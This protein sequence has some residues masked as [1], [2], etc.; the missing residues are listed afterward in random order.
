MTKRTGMPDMEVLIYE[1]NLVRV[2][3]SCNNVFVKLIGEERQKKHLVVTALLSRRISHI[4]LRKLV[5]ENSQP[6]YGLFVFRDY[7]DERFALVDSWA[8][9]VVIWDSREGKDEA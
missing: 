7:L 4:Q 2:G 6:T 5:G 9:S 3:Y 8:D 1:E